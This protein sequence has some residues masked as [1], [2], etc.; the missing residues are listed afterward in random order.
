[1]TERRKK[2][3]NHELY[4]AQNITVETR[5]GLEHQIRFFYEY[6]LERARKEM[7]EHAISL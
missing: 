2:D 7:I 4:I 6:H 3:E 5:V 1:M